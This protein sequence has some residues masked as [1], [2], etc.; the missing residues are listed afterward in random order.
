MKKH[1]EDNPFVKCPYFKCEERQTIFCE[2][3]EENSAIHHAFSTPQQRK[4]YQ[5]R[6]CKTNWKKCL[7]A[8]GLNRKYEYEQR[9]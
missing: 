6:F 9:G 8:D 5:T 1:R 4:D 3:A 7:V 2:G